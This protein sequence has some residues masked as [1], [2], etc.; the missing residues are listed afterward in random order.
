MNPDVRN[1]TVQWANNLTAGDEQVELW[2]KEGAG[3]WALA[4]TVAVLPV[5]T[6]THEFVGLDAGAIFAFQIRHSRGGT[7]RPDYES[8]DPDDWPA[9][10]LLEYTA[11]MP[12]PVLVSN[13]WERTS[14]TDH[15]I[16]LSWSNTVTTRATKVYR[17]DGG[18]FD[19]I[20]TVPAGTDAYDYEI[21]SGE[22]A[23]ELDFKVAQADDDAAE[24][25]S[26]TITA[27]AGPAAPTNMAQV[28]GPNWYEYSLSW[29]MGQAGAQTRIS[30]HY[31]GSYQNR[32]L[33]VAD[34]T[35]ATVS[36]LE[37]N[38]AMEPNGND[39]VDV[40]VRIRHEITQFAVT[41]VSQWVE[42]TFVVDIA[43]DETAYGG[44]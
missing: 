14:G 36:S 43:T 16:H 44:P 29:T 39:T 11:D 27:Y 22:E 20:D 30:D 8:S 26:N 9:E 10:S 17:D 38:S 37:K 35:S 4:E 28:G 6:Q 41:D 33:T 2:K 42:Q 24:T 12:V 3:A 7:Y 21:Q 40:L 32:T 15:V 25:D 5:D 13:G 18:G 34:L 23:T 19:L 1:I 31:T